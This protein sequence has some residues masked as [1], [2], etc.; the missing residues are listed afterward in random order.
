[1]RT[2]ITIVKNIRDD[3]A[4]RSS[5]NRL[6]ERTFGLNFENW[7]QNGYW[8]N[9]YIPYSIVR[10]GQVI[11]NV[12]VNPMTFSDSGTLHH[13]VQL[14]TVMTDPDFRGQGLC[15]LLMEAVEHDW[16]ERA[17][18]IYLFANDTVLDFYPRFGFQRAQEYRFFAPL[19]ACM[20]EAFASVLQSPDAAPSQN[21]APDRP[22]IPVSMTDPAN[23]AALERAVLSGVSQGSFDMAGNPGLILFYA[24]QFLTENVWY[25]PAHDAW[26]IAEAEGDTLLLDAI[27]APRPV[28]PRE[29]AAAL[30]SGAFRERFPQAAHGLSRLECGFTPA[31]IDESDACRTENGSVW[32]VRPLE[33][34]DDALF[35]KGELVKTFAQKNRR[36]PT[37]SHA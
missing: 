27:F 22:A 34:D 33:N 14:G 15:R 28:D 10:Q 17:E 18:A 24:S 6:A 11:A 37:L 32:E 1:M 7:Y 12:S 21:T 36:F 20:P 19:S 8:K 23:R 29:A 5:F 30:L 16:A 25:L 35:I 2:D 26:V 13:Y 3:A 9:N 31:G 4:L